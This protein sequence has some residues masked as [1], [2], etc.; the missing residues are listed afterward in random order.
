MSTKPAH[1]HPLGPPMREYREHLFFGMRETDES[2]A[3]T[4]EWYAYMQGRA[5]VLRDGGATS[6]YQPWPT[7][8]PPAPPGDE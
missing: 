2:K 3:R 4:R 1:L 7:A 8:I 5:D 6:C